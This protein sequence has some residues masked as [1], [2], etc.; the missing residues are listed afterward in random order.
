GLTRPQETNQMSN[1]SK[2]IEGTA[3]EIGG[4][5]KGTIGKLIGNDRLR[6]EGK[7]KELEGKATKE[8]AK[9]AERGKG[10]IEEVVG[11]VKSR[12]GAVLDDERMEAKGRVKELKGE[13]RQR[14]NR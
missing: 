2:R 14:A 12:V 9:S 3:E 8:A 6:A 11:A 5:V 10:K 13:A 1:A 7:V 4:K